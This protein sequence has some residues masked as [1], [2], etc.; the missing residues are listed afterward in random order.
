[1]R[2]A[3]GVDKGVEGVLND[4][5]MLR[6]Q[7]LEGGEKREWRNWKLMEVT[8]RKRKEESREREQQKRASVRVIPM[9]HTIRCDPGLGQCTGNS[10]YGDGQSIYVRICTYIDVWNMLTFSLFSHMNSIFFMKTDI[11]PL[12]IP[13]ST[14][15]LVGAQPQMTV[16][17]VQ[18][19][20]LY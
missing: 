15:T 9:I 4:E 10:W 8:G 14:S 11:L 13:S 2:D 20:L 3:L 19:M 5:R 6:R 16:L 1:M 12:F 7:R 17:P 18:Y